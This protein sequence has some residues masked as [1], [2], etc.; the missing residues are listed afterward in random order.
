ME[1]PGADGDGLKELLE[2]WEGEGPMPRVL[3]HKIE[4]EIR[5]LGSNDVA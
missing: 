5:Y 1:G 4:K 3:N 2:S